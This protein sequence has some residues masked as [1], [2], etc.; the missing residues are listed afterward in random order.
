MASINLIPGAG[1]TFVWPLV[2]G[3]TALNAFL[4]NTGVALTMAF[5]SLVNGGTSED[6]GTIG[7][8]V[9]TKVLDVKAEGA[10][11]FT[12]AIQSVGMTH[13]HRYDV[14]SHQSW[15]PWHSSIQPRIVCR[16]FALRIAAR[17]ASARPSHLN[18]QESL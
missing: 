15:D 18:D 3:N 2:G 10:R 6:G 16:P 8:P 7:F 5:G 13:W 1:A 12:F 4:D 17:P 11:L 14:Q 9:F